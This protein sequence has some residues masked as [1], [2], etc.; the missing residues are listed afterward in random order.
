MPPEKP[1]E[2]NN[3]MIFGQDQGT[4]PEASASSLSAIPRV[5]AKDLVV[6]QIRAAIMDGELKPG[7]RLTEPS[8]A[9]TLGVGQATIREA[10][11]ELQHTGF[12]Q[13]S[14]PRKTF[15]T[16][17]SVAEVDQ[18]FAVRLPLELAA[19]EMLA[20]R[21]NCPL[22]ACDE[23][24]RSMLNAARAG[25]LSELKGFDMEFHRGL[26]A[27]TGNVYLKEVL[28]RLATKLFAFAF[29]IIQPS[30]YTVSQLVELCEKHGKILALVRAGDAEQAKRLMIESM[31]R[32]WVKDVDS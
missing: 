23:S 28:E 20:S 29:A 32:S 24:Y 17:L 15:V 13:R 19:L 14:K 11:I 5:S 2:A 9:R 1:R 10:L 18:I 27:A 22:S 16:K 12:V 7:Q 25:N 6:R 31:D 3:T 26:W 30:H 8:L 4:A 21:P